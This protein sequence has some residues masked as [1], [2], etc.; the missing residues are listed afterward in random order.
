MQSVH[1]EEGAVWLQISM[2]GDL[3][4]DIIYRF[5]TPVALKIVSDMMGGMTVTEL[6]ELGQSAIAEIGNMISGNA[7]TILYSKGITIDITPPKMIR[8]EQ[9]GNP[10]K[11]ILVP[12]RM[13]GVG[14]VA[15]YV[16]F[17][18]KKAS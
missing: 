15:I 5:P 6:D 7:S 16:Q 12:L 9:Q 4:G 10:S 14:E 8:A 13:D 2:I 11:A 17:R 3:E 18:S 1:Y